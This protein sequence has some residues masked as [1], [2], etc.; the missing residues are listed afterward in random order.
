[1]LQ[2]G[3]TGALA[4]NWVGRRSAVRTAFNNSFNVTTTP[5]GMKTA[6][7]VTTAARKAVT[8][9]ALKAK[10]GAPL[11]PGTLSGAAEG[12]SAKVLAKTK[13]PGVHVGEQKG[14]EE[15]VTKATEKYG[16]SGLS[17]A[18]GFVNKYFPII[19]MF[20]S[21]KELY[22]VATGAES[23]KDMSTFDKGLALVSGSTGVVAGLASTFVVGVGLLGITAVS[24]PVLAGVAAVGA[25]TFAIS[26]I[27]SL[28]SMAKG[29]VEWGMKWVGEQNQVV[30]GAQG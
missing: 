5:A 28:A 22:D 7:R 10:P 21:G 20:A 14:M 2:V 4:A 12:A 26:N 3:A 17:K 18:A 29:A 15:A 24:A 1:L 9:E 6:E 19:G 30:T 13:T 27:T 8:K 16:A 25:A 23:T 11:A